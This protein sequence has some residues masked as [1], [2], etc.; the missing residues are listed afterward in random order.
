VATARTAN[1]LATART[2]NGVAAA[3]NVK[4][5]ATA[6]NVKATAAARRLS[7][8]LPPRRARAR[9]MVAA[10]VGIVLSAGVAA[11]NPQVR[12]NDPIAAPG[13]E[14]LSFPAPLPGTYELP[15]L[16]DAAGGNVVDSDGT[17][18]TLAE[19]MAGRI[20]VMAFVYRSCPDR[21][22]CPLANFVMSK[23][24]DAVGADTGL[25]Q[26]VRLLSL[27][28][29]PARDRPEKMAE[30]AKALVRP[31]VSWHF[32]TTDSPEALAP[33]LE[34]YGQSIRHDV[35]QDGKPLATIS[36]VLRVFLIDARG[37]IRNIYSSS[38][39]HAQTVL[40]DIRTLAAE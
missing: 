29:D 32:L 21:N 3:R 14:E 19:L 6:R 39:L 26:R 5:L 8:V 28:L 10:A 33:I 9:G 30:L 34:S 22:G 23:V 7:F 13:W 36:H 35:D 16:G 38:Y 17:R 15:P 2:A 25:Q 27:S 24:R 31:S 12:T 4:A 40:A 11:A 18:R 20:V 1:A 37:R